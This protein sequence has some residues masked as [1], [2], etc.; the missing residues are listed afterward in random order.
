MIAQLTGTVAGLT[1][2]AIVVSVS[3]VGFEVH[4]TAKT[5]RR[6]A[7]G[8]TISLHTRLVVREDALQLFG[9]D[10]T[11]DRESFDLLCSIS[12][13]GP[14]LALSILSQLDTQTLAAAVSSQ[15]EALLRSISGVGPK[16][17]KLILLSL[18]GKLNPATD[19]RLVS[20][21]VGL[22]T[23][24]DVAARVASEVDAGLDDSQALKAAL[25][26]L[27]SGKLS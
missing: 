16:T 10:E 20:A 22:G 4:A 5:I 14:K 8:D 6:V 9:F 7:I 11:A 27:G 2:S 1:G 23:A 13:V 12:G 24:P 18:S 26:I 19:S 25:A 15:N 21:L 3:G 17:A